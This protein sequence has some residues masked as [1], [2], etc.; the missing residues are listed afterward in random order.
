MNKLI[1]QKLIIFDIVEKKSKTVSFNDGINIVTS[2]GNQ[3]GKSTIMKSIYYTLG[4]EVFFADRF[5]LKTKIH[6]LKFDVRGVQYTFIRHGDV[7]AIKN[8]PN[9][10]KTS[11]ASQLSTF[12]QEIIGFSVY[13][14]DKQKKYTIA[15]PVFYYVPYYIDQDHGWSSELKS[16]NNLGQFDKKSRDRLFYYHLTIL[17][18]D[19]GNKIKDKEK[20]DSDIESERKKKNEILG[21]LTYINN[22]ITSFNLEL[23]LNILEIQRKEILSRYKGYSYDLNNIRRKILE[24][25]EELF[26]IENV[27]S[28]INS[29]IKQND[30]TKKEIIHQFNVECPHCS[31]LFEI[32]DKDILKIN[33]SIADLDASK[34][35][36]LDLREKVLDKL[37]KVKK[38]FNEYEL[39]LKAIEEEKVNSE[40]TMEDILKFKGLHE[41]RKQLNEQ[42]AS[43]VLELEIKLDSL[44]S[45][46]DKLKVWHDSIASADSRYREILSENLIRFNTNEHSLPKNFTIG[47]NFK[48][49]GSGQVRVN[50]ARVYSFIK[51]LEEYNQNGLKLPLVIDSPKGGEQ[52]ISNSE[53]ILELLTEKAHISNQIILATID[54]EDFYTG[55]KKQFNIIKLKN[56]EYSLLSKEDYMANKKTIDFYISLYFDVI[57][58]FE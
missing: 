20:L 48:A 25:Q 57:S 12:V 11:S 41:T 10:F 39:K 22:N 54:F 7:V 43:I 40:Y 23:D 18:E 31:N 17:D 49:S 52:S 14:E 36:M 33:Y 50:L 29:T 53:L 44:K 34:L 1:I 46:K 42:L 45:I 51:L 3:V 9:L 21:L 47:K 38:D 35:E 30:K 26:K 55:D 28:N 58:N 5:N 32:Q 8:G 19:Y 13:L 16:F 15:P 4:A 2:K 37:K 24:Y 56:N 27:I 6:I